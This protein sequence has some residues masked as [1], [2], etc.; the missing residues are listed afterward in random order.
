LKRLCYLIYQF[1]FGHSDQP[2]RDNN[3]A[4]P[5][6]PVPQRSRR[7]AG[8]RVTVGWVHYDWTELAAGVYRARLPFLDVSVGAVAG[9]AGLLLIDC[10]TTLT[11]AAAVAD[12]LL[13]I[14][15]G[16]VTHVV[17]THHHF[18][19]VL[20]SAGFPDARSYA[21]PPVAVA[22][23]DRLDVLCAEA[24]RYGADPD[25]VARTG[26]AV[27]PPGHGVWHAEL[28]L[29]GRTV[30]VVHPGP[31]H[32]DHDLVAVIPGTP[33]VVFCGDLVE[34]S[35]DPAVGVDADPAAWPATL[36]RVLALGG[37]AAVYVPGHG[38]AVDAD[39]VRRQRDWLKI[40][41]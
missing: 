26:R 27:N 35:G 3:D 41:Y 12:D 14:T 33:G 32:T 37:E 11:E 10:G 8:R 1:Q 4:T 7:W 30:R 9:D 18:D 39:F 25:D 15:G 20:G 5:D 29:G 23:T 31:G 2:L 36:D 6:V 16:S 22:L 28:D 13:E 38:A 24:L 21:A 17:M 19:H 34:E 40:R